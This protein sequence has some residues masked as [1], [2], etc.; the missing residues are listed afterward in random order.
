MAAATVDEYL[1]GVPDEMRV[2]LERLRGQIR[3]T[4]P[5]ATETIS[6]GIPAFKLGGRALVWFAAWKAHCSIYPLTDTFMAEHADELKGYRRT[7][8]S[9]H[10][11]PQEPLPEPVV[12]LLVEA[13]L[14]DLERG[15]G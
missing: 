7:K 8:G 2:A 13:R 14:A 4:A 15:E 5:D 11:T 1:A 3:A 12:V 10:F 6:Y 9:V